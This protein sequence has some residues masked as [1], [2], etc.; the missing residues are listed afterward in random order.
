MW[1]YCWQEKTTLSFQDGSPM[2][3]VFYWSLWAINPL[4]SGIQ[5]QMLVWVGPGETWWGRCWAIPCSGL[6]AVWAS[7]SR[8]DPSHLMWCAVSWDHLCVPWETLPY[9]S[10]KPPSFFIWYIPTFVKKLIDVVLLSY[11]G[12]V[13]HNLFTGQEECNKEKREECTREGKCGL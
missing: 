10:A 13:N 9:P 5:W 12:R 6:S 4:F 11:L 7:T 8:S 2:A 3:A 1:E